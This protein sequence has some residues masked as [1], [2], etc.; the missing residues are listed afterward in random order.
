MS[1][2][3]NFLSDID[4]AVS[5]SGEVSV[6]DPNPVP[7]PASTPNDGDVTKD[8]RDTVEN[9][10][11]S[12]FDA[13]EG[14]S[15]EPET[16]APA[17][18]KEPPAD[19]K[20]APAT[21]QET[22]ATTPSEP[23]DNDFK[24]HNRALDTFLK[25]DDKGNLV[26]SDGEIIAAAGKA[27]AHFEAVKKAGRVH[28]QVGA[29]MAQQLQGLG[30]KFRE[31][32]QQF[33]EMRDKKTVEVTPVASLV[34]ELSVSEAQAKQALDIMK[35]YRSDP[36]GA[37]K[38]MLTQAH[39]NGIDVSKIGAN[40]TA[41]PSVLRN[42]I[43]ETMAAQATPK[44][45]DTPPAAPDQPSQAQIDEARDFLQ[46]NPQANRFAAQIGAARQQFP[47]LS[48]QDI[49]D[50]VRRAIM[51]QR[52][53]KPDAAKPAT[54]LVKEQAQA[55]KPKP[56]PQA[57]DYGKMSFQEIAASVMKDNP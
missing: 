28:R 20:A 32:Y 40:V 49:W 5:N 48:Y 53:N 6:P 22:P 43:T 14:V 45:Q 31:L 4:S 24:S 46:K 18:G 44:E 8:V 10:L 19:D 13:A 34:K 52:Y 38:M 50:G 17:D 1:G 12:M 11:T 2:E 41:D 27:R 51:K 26:N 56:K 9:D 35:A 57:V 23:A 21:T 16:P 42:L 7:Q 39:A 3:D 55:P 47:H 37:I 33:S 29:Q 54:K 25:E 15:A 36:I 30:G